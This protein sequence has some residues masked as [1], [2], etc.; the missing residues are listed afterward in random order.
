ME[1]AA[2]D[3]HE[4][5]VGNHEGHLQLVLQDE[6]VRK[7]PTDRQQKSL[8]RDLVLIKTEM[9]NVA[10]TVE[11]LELGS[12]LDVCLLKQH[13]EQIS[14]IKGK[15][16]NISHNIVTLDKEYIGMVDRRFAIWKAIFSTHLQIRRLLQAP[17][18]ALLQEAI[19][20]PKINVLIFKRDIMQW[21]TI[22]KQ[23]DDSVHNKPQLSY[24]VK[25]AC[26]RQAIKDGPA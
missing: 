4:H 21:Q 15:L 8:H 11:V 7:Q 10:N 3:D 14:S 17:T 2:L 13:E 25:L 9:R 5:R 18:P 26:L 6:P 22:S 19:K 12:E 1:Q 24:P 23:F 16:A 20:L